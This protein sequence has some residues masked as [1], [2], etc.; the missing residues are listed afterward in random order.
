MKLAGLAMRVAAVLVLCATGAWAQAVTVK[1]D[2][3]YA[4]HDGVPLYGDLYLPG[5]PGPH[6]A[7]MLIHGGAWKVGSKAAFSGSWGPYLAERGYVVFSIDY[8]LSKPNVPSWPQAL[9]DVKAALQYLRGSAAALGVDPERIAVGGDSA[10]GELSAMLALTQNWPA[11]AARYPADPFAGQ[12]TSVRAV[13]PAYG[14]F[15][16]PTW[17]RWTK[18]GYRPGALEY[19]ALEELFGGAPD[20]VPAAYFE[21]S[22]MNYVRESA[23][24][25]KDLALPNPGLRTPWFVTWGEED[26][27]VPAGGQSVPFVQALREA[28]AEVVAAPVPHVG[29]FWFSRSRLTGQSGV[30]TG[31]AMESGNAMRCQAATPNDF[32]GP[33]LLEFLGRHLGG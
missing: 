29:H 20:Q 4:T 27:I 23:T 24:V 3:L 18:A 6:P 17:W 13:I 22:P 19:S 21:A 2:V 1:T 33:R 7:L 32:I 11:F 26:P 12:S 15:S 25:L 8:R 16:M 14:V 9:L 10:G 5:S 31:C 30:P 28:G